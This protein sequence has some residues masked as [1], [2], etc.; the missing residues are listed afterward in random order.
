[1]RARATESVRPGHGSG[2]RRPSPDGGMKASQVPETEVPLPRPAPPVDALAAR[3]DRADLRVRPRPRRNTSHLRGV[4]RRP[5]GCTRPRAHSR[6]SS[7]ARATASVRFAAPSLPRT[8]P[9]CFLKRRRSRI[10]SEQGAP[11]LANAT[12]TARLPGYSTAKRPDA[13]ANLAGTVCSGPAG[14]Q[15]SPEREGQPRNGQ[16]TRP[17]AEQLAV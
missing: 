7:R 1:M 9:T 5:A 11:S 10:V 12:A 15:R 16:P 3:R 6:F 13:L 14:K 8:W 4:L 2:H 17:A